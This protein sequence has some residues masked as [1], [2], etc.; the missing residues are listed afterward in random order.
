MHMPTQQKPAGTSDSF[1]SSCAPRVTFSFS[2][3]YCLLRVIPSSLVHDLMHSSDGKAFARKGIGPF[4]RKRGAAAPSEDNFAD[5]DMF[6]RR[7]WP[8]MR[9]EIDR[10]RQPDII[11]RIQECVEAFILPVTFYTA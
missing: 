10:P 9:V 6:S 7:R 8:G 4:L 5:G 3:Y 1:P 11:S 2:F